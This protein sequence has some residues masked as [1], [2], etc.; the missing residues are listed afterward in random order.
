MVRFLLPCSGVAAPIVCDCLHEHVCIARAQLLHPSSPA[1]DKGEKEGA[2][3]SELGWKRKG[4]ARGE[5]GMGV[6]ENG[7]GGVQAAGA[8]RK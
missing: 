2:G 3:V 8:M 5:R 1:W 4:R 7:G 6:G